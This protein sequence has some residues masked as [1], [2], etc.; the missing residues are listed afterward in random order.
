MIT[1]NY[2]K[3]ILILPM[4][5][6]FGCK[7]T[8]QQ[9]T[10][11]KEILTECPWEDDSIL[12]KKV[13]TKVDSMPEFNGGNI[14]VLKYFKANYKIPNNTDDFQASFKFEFVI[15]VDGSVIGERI[16]GKSREQ[17]TELEKEA[18]NVLRNMPKWRIGKCKGHAVPVKMVLPLKL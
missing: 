5:L 3:F 16:K 6:F 9:Q 2:L 4:F 13:Y 10:T 14:A 1:D 15:D 17:L 8:A 11:T 12:H 18:L 7:S